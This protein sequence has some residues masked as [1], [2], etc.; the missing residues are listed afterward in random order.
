MSPFQ[1]LQFFTNCSNSVPF[2]WLQS[3]KNRRLQCGLPTGSQPSFRHPPAPVSVSFPSCRWISAYLWTS[4]G[5]RGTAA[6]PW[7]APQ[8]TGEPQ[9]QLPGACPPSPSLLTLMSAELFLSHILTPLFSECNYIC[10]VSFFYPLQY[11]ITEVLLPSLMGLAL[12]SSRSV[13]ESAVIGS[14]RYQGSFQQLL[15][16]ATPVVPHSCYQN[17]AIQNQYNDILV[18]LKKQS[19]EINILDHTIL[20]Q[21]RKLNALAL[22]GVFQKVSTDVE[23][24]PNMVQ[25]FRT[26]QCYLDLPGL[27]ESCT[28]GLGGMS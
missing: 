13:L 12:T 23:F 9:L 24:E 16:E 3:F 2:H 25:M 8:A 18:Q 6:S 1:S 17:S 26:L 22:T 15:T 27:T 11:I 10:T 28:R 14:V 21:I 7:S 19:S 20:L 5:C 4:I